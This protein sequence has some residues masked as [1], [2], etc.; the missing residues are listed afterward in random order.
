MNKQDLIQYEKEIAELWDA[1]KIKYPVHLSGGNEDELIEIFA[2]I[3]KEDWV[4][5]THRNHYHYL[6]KGGSPAKLTGMIMQGHSMHV[7]DKQCNFFA[8]GIVAGC[9]AIAVGVAKAIKDERHV[10]CFVGD[11]ATDE[12]HFYEAVRYAYGCDLPITFIIEDNKRSVCTTLEQRYS[13]YTGCGIVNE[14]VQHYLYTPTYPHVGTGKTVKF[15]DMGEVK[16][17]L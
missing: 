14:K 5:S 13:H 7:M 1:G 16:E 4:F 9:C 11:G 17:T 3:K 2:N 12:G 10:W 8:S 6:L 15:A